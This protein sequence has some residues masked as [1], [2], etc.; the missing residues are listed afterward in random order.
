MTN[1]TEKQMSKLKVL[2]QLN[3]WAFC[4]YLCQTLATSFKFYS[5]GP[6]LD[7]PAAKQSSK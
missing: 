2:G 1:P 5:C 4:I 6:L 7:Q 3:D